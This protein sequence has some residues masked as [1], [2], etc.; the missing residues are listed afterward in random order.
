MPMFNEALREEATDPLYN[1]ALIAGTPDQLFKQAAAVAMVLQCRH[2][3]R[4]A[5]EGQQFPE[6]A[7]KVPVPR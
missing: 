4:K 6:T 3:Q 1:V 2:A 5:P 7:I